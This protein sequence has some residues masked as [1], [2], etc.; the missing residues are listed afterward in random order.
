MNKI[1]LFILAFGLGFAAG[2]FVLGWLCTSFFHDKLE[3]LETS[4]HTRFAALETAVSAHF[5]R[6]APAPATTPVAP[7][8]PADAK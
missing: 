6:S 2:A 3:Q 1:E 5:K 7:A 8:T 4:L